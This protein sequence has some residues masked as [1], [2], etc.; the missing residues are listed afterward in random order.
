MLRLGT[1]LHSKGFSITVA[2]TQFNSPNTR[3]NHPDFVFLPLLSLS[4][5]NGSDEFASF[6]SKLNLSYRASLHELL[7]RIVEE[8]QEEQ[9][10][11]SPCVIYDALMYSVEAVTHSLKLPSIILRTMN[12]ISWLTY[13]AYPRLREEGRIPSQG[14]ESM[15]LVPGF[16]SIRFK[17]LP[18]FD[19]KNEDSLLEL[20]ATV[21]NTGTSSAIIWNSWFKKL[22]L[23]GMQSLHSSGSVPLGCSISFKAMR[24]RTEACKT[25][26]LH[27]RNA[28]EVECKR[29]KLNIDDGKPPKYFVCIRFDCRLSGNKLLSHYRN[30]VCG[31]G[32]HMGS[33]QVLSKK[34][35]EGS[36]FDAR[37]RGV[38]LKGLTQFIITDALEVMPAS[39]GSML[40]L[41]YALQVTDGKIIE[42]HSFHIGVDKVLAL[43]KNSLVEEAPLTKTLLEQN[44]EPELVKADFCC[45]RYTKS[46]MTPASN[47]CEGICL[48]LTISKSKNIVCYAEASEDFV[49]LLFSFLTVPFGYIMKEM[50]N[51]FGGCIS[52]LYKS[53]EKLDAEQFLKS[54]K[55]KEMLLSPKL[56]PDF[57][58][59]NHPLSIEEDIHPPYYYELLGYYGCGNKIYELSSDK[60]STINVEYSTLT[61]MDPKS[62]FKEATS[63]GFLMGPAKFTVT[64][65]LIITPV[66]PIKCLSL[67]NKLE[68]SLNDVKECLVHVGYE[69]ALKLLQASLV[70]E[71]A[72][73]NAFLREANP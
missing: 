11:G 21:R 13:F 3:H 19:F 56:A 25:M 30:A 22:N 15:E 73:T 23:K 24:F 17:D 4:Q 45:G 7:T 61:V 63:G 6:L 2:H 50:C 65:D 14:S 35:S 10:E 5:R 59:E 53:V 43:L 37:D 26:L 28:A 54:C 48:M 55:H 67:L 60:P 68:V 58:Y 62:R 47:T 71:S 46:R 40:S 64:D 32:A 44:P 34:E 72:L 66:S 38:F 18:A 69:E 70:S 41:L 31:C 52:H 49:D 29:L 9:R 1:I 39:A 42:E 36:V 16:H 12:A 27:P 51:T 33:E 8:E 57:S 20:T